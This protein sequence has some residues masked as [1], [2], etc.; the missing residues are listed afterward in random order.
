[1][2]T[3]TATK[4]EDQR[5]NLGVTVIWLVVV[6][7]VAIIDMVCGCH[8]L[9]PSW[10][11]AVLYNPSSSGRLH[12]DTLNKLAASNW[13]LTV[14]LCQLP[15]TA[16][17]FRDLGVTFDTRLTSKQHVDNGVVHICFYQLQTAT[18]SP[19]IATRRRH[20]HPQ[21]MRSPPA[22]LT[23]AT[24]SYMASLPKSLVGCRQYYKLL[25]NR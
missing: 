9:W 3:T 16:D 11:V 21:Y 19:T 10:F 5:H 20:L 17:A 12:M 6:I 8:C 23:I 18:V 25:P 22:A 4:R 1:M 14:F 15:S 7:A 24:L 2:T 13:S